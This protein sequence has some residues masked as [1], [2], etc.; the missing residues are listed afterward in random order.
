MCVVIVYPAVQVGVGVGAL[1]LLGLSSH[2]TS[3]FTTTFVDPTLPVQ[4]PT[5]ST[6]FCYRLALSLMPDSS[7]RKSFYAFGREN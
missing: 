4:T 1:F 6:A 5:R 2:Y 7:H 3:V